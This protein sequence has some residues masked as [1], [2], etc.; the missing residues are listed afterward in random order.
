MLSSSRISYQM[1]PA[2]MLELKKQV[3]ELEDL[4]F[5]RLGTLPWGALVLFIKKNDGTFQ[6][7]I[8]YSDLNKVT[9]QE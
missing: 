8:D 9:Y 2:K 6:L 7:C 5:V 1:A 4:G 3:Q